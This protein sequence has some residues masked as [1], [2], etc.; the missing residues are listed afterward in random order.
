[1]VLPLP[2][3]LA[4][5]PVFCASPSYVGASASIS[6]FVCFLSFFLFS[7]IVL[8]FVGEIS[9]ADPH[10]LQHSHNVALILAEMHKLHVP[11]RQPQLT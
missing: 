4:L 6:A 11:V 7:F 3:V 1:V 10:T 8:F 9:S 2:G 5:V